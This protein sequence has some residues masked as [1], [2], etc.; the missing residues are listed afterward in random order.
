[1]ITIQSFRSL[2]NDLGTLTVNKM[3]LAKVGSTFLLPTQ[4]TP[5]QQ[6]CFELLGVS[7]RM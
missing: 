4:P 6:R 1:M 3:Q 5:V 2:M 7:P